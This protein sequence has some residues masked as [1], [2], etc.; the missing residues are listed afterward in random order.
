MQIV[1]LS[2][3][4]MALSQRRP[5]NAHAIAVTYILPSIIVWM[6]RDVGMRAVL[7]VQA[8]LFQHAVEMIWANTSPSALQE[9]LNPV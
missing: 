7:I 9:R 4:V 5:P 8:V 1:N 2:A 6:I 3:Q